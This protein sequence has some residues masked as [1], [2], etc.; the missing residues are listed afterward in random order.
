MPFLICQSEWY[1]VEITD[2][3]GCVVSDSV[4]IKQPPE[5]LATA[6]A[7]TTE[8]CEDGVINLTATY[9]GGRDGFYTHK[10]TGTGAAYLNSTD[11]LTPEFSGALAGNYSLIYTVKDIN[12]CIAS[13]TIEII[14]HPPIKL[15]FDEIDTLCEFSTPPPLSKVDKNGIT[16]TWSP[17][18]IL[19]DAAGT[20]PLCFY[21]GFNF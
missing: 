12:D 18:T 5:L 8:I 9:E 13:D 15:V 20:Y 1:K 19:T 6:D 21:S 4:E 14:V 7:D 3:A 17:D 2:A 10:W 11:I 16:G